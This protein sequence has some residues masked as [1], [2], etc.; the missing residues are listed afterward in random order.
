MSHIFISYSRQD[1]AYV[2]LLAQALES[3][4]LPVWLDNHIDYGTTWPR[5]IQDHL[6]Q[7]QAFVVVMS[8]RSEESHW[9]QCELTHALELKK[10]IFPLL[11]EGRRWFSVAT[12]QLVDVTDGTVPPARFF[13]ILS[14]Y[15]PTLSPIAESL[16]LQEVIEESIPIELSLITSA[17]LAVTNI[18]LNASLSE[19]FEQASGENG[20]TPAEIRI[21]DEINNQQRL[22]SRIRESIQLVLN[23]NEDA[24]GTFDIL[25]EERKWLQIK[26]K[27]INASYPFDKYPSFGHLLD[28]FNGT[29]SSKLESWE[30]DSYV[31]F[32]FPDF[33]QSDLH[34]A[35]LAAWIYSY[36]TDILECPDLFDFKF[37]LE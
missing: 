3:H 16:P 1:Q 8:P 18:S 33:D 17:D 30:S 36:F 24:F 21:N 13:E 9:V 32:K 4:H 22:L 12:L 28:K 19:H 5:I 35:E 2:N 34:Q 29:L 37:E 15:F 31:C 23:E 20:T 7:C 25:G 27:L 6:E 10:P 14:T 26:G 11:L